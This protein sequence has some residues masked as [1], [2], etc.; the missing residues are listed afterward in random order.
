M[1]ISAN[2]FDLEPP[3]APV[4]ITSTIKPTND[5]IVNP[6]KLRKKKKEE[7]TPTPILKHFLC[8]A[9]GGDDDDHDNYFV[10]CTDAASPPQKFYPTPTL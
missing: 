6:I 10:Y 1:K 8:L 5:V 4:S 3:S 9:D 7:Q 2:F